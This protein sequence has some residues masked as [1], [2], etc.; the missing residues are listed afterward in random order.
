MTVR[1]MESLQSRQIRGLIAVLLF[2]A[3]IPLFVSFYNRYSLSSSPPL[4]NQND[5]NY[6]VE[7]IVNG[8]SRGIYFTPPQM[9]L[10]EL[11]LLADIGNPYSEDITLKNA[12]QLIIKSSHGNYEIHTGKMAAATRLSLNIPL[13]I[14]DVSRDDLLLITGIGE[15][16][17]DKI[18]KLREKRGRLKRLED[19]MQI[20]GI[21]ENKLEKLRKYL[22]VES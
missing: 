6:A 14:N 20:E 13:D 11:L 12:M 9:L 22:C 15:I 8:I 21:K 4:I 3:V 5:D 19:L 7:L 1:P 2:M 18:I 16:T 17:A 10:S